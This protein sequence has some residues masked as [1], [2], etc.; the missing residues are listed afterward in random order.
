MS[1]LSSENMIFVAEIPENKEILEDKSVYHVNDKLKELAES[2]IRYLKD[3]CNIENSIEDILDQANIT[4]DSEDIDVTVSVGIETR[5]RH[6]L[7]F[8]LTKK[9]G[10]CTFRM[11]SQKS[12]KYDLNPLGDW[13]N[14]A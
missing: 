14:E 6:V 4:Y 2:R 10:E 5:K 9:V 11:I 3:S 7:G 12:S 1:K 13:E 8:R